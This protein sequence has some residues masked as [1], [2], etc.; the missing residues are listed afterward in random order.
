MRGNS[1]PLNCQFNKGECMNKEQELYE[2]S[3]KLVNS[4]ASLENPSL[5]EYTRMHKEANKIRSAFFN[6]ENVD[7][8]PAPCPLA[9]RIITTRCQAFLDKDHLHPYDD[10][11]EVSNPLNWEKIY[12]FIDEEIGGFCKIKGTFH[13]LDA[14]ISDLK[15]VLDDFKS[16]GIEYHVF[17]VDEEVS[18]HTSDE[19]C[20]YT[21]NIKYGE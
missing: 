12:E 15:I 19:F 8:E 1:A 11:S 7:V 10:W 5:P 16:R 9:E 14:S 2:W 17:L 21:P 4:L 13:Y 20:V 18:G 3:R 6:L